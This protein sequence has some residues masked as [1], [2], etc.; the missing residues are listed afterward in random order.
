MHISLDFRCRKW[1]GN[2]AFRHVEW[3]FKHRLAICKKTCRGA[4]EF[5][6][7]SILAE[8]RKLEKLMISTPHP[9]YWFYCDFYCNRRAILFA[10]AR[11]DSSSQWVMKKLALRWGDKTM[12]RWF[13]I[14]YS[15]QAKELGTSDRVG[16]CCT[17]LTEECWETM[18]T[19]KG[20]RSSKLRAKK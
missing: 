9:W 1:L 16:I 20:F 7:V 3:R 15:V 12:W 11:S 2:A 14:F 6:L 5:D 18:F 8:R 10:S 19:R 4:V 17:A 13:A